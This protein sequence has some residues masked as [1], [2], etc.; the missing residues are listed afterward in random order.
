MLERKS[1]KN[2]GSTTGKVLI[3]LFRDNNLTSDKISVLRL[4][5]GVYAKTEKNLFI[6]FKS[7]IYYPFN[8]FISKIKNDLNYKN[9]I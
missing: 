5:H 3:T 4:S 1:S 8:F 2:P 9:K 7:N 6:I